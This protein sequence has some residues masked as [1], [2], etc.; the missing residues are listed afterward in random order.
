MIIVYRSY[1]CM[2][3]IPF[4]RDSSVRQATSEKNVGVSSVVK[5]GGNGLIL[6]I[7]SLVL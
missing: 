1:S 7:F 2:S 4:V 3:N 5:S 6:S